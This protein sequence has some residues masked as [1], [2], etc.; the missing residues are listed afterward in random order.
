MQ[1]VKHKMPEQAAEERRR[2]F[3]EVALGYD[4]AI[5]KAEASRCLQCKTAPCRQGCPVE[6]NIPQFIKHIKDGDF[7]AAIDEIKTKNNLP[8]VCGRVCPQ[9]DQCEKFCVMGK[10]GEPVG[11]GRLERF[12]ADYAMAKGRE[13]K[14]EVPTEVLGKV[15]VIGAGPA[16]LTTAGDLARLGYKV[17][18]FEAL[19]AAGGVLMYGIPEFRLPKAIVQKEIAALRKLGVDIQVNAVIGKT[20]TIDELLSEEGYDAVFIGTGAGLPHFMDIPGENLNGVYSAN[21]FLTR[22]NLMKAYKFPH[23]GTPVRVGRS[24]AVI[25]GGNVAMDSA[26]T[27][28]RLGA[29]KVYIVY[30]RSMDELP[31][32][33]EEVEHAKEEGVDFRLLTAP[34]QVLGD[35]KGWVRGIE[36]IRMELGEPDASGRRSPVPVKD[37]NFVIDVETVVIA[38]GQGPNPLVQ[39]TTPGLAV[40][41]RGNIVADETGATSKSGVFAG[42]D[43]VTGAATVILAM[44]AGKKAAAKIH[45]YVQNK[46]NAR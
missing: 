28:L 8:A 9:E 25:G 33:H 44:G 32:R 45:E 22:V 18:V 2:N 34:V 42:G 38:I 5:A 24:V 26:R 19:H 27:A 7:D 37:S 30:R 15:A 20:Y 14:A 11:I 17:T 29:E 10:K 23:T 36:C 4:A 13:D 46:K 35:D 43:I 21:E 40:N 39:N 1:Q 3:N 16:G 31:A 12:A 6:I 41:K